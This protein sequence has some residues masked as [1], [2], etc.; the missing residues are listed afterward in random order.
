M[1]NSNQF[2]WQLWKQ[3]I[4]CLLSHQNRERQH[5]KSPPQFLFE[6]WPWDC[7]S[8]AGKGVTCGQQVPPFLSPAWHTFESWRCGL[9]L[10]SRQFTEHIVCPAFN[11]ACTKRATMSYTQKQRVLC[12]QKQ[13][14]T[15]VVTSGDVCTHN[16]KTKGCILNYELLRRNICPGNTTQF[17]LYYCSTITLF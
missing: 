15:M 12:A 1:R 6:P 7:T 9:D 10:S 2:Y 16:L 14:W 5:W 8:T 3:Q 13:C 11:T 4:L 17:M